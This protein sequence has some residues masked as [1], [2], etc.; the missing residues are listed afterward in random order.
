MLDAKKNKAN[1]CK[2]KTDS[3]GTKCRDLPLPPT[4]TTPG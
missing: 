1:I 4:A 3:K 2:L